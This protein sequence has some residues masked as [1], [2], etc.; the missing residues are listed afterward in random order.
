MKLN[1]DFEVRTFLKICKSWK[2]EKI[3][4]LKILNFCNCWNFENLKILKKWLMLRIWRKMEAAIELLR[5]N[6]VYTQVFMSIGKNLKNIET[7]YIFMLARDRSFC[8]QE[9]DL[10]VGKRE[11]CLSARKASV[12]WQERDLSAGKREICLWA[13]KRS[14]CWLERDLSAG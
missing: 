7:I 5:S 6:Y 4:I 12:C 9:R 3:E 14:V 13:R 10:P 2:V 11:V 8:W 1:F